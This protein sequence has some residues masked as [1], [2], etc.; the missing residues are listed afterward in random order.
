LVPKLPLQSNFCDCGVFALHYAEEFIK[1]N[2]TI[3]ESSIKNKM[4]D[5]LGIDWFS[6]D[7]I[8]RKRMLIKAIVEDCYVVDVFEK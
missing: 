2:C 6:L 7:E 3:T 1:L 5:V 4:A 8:P